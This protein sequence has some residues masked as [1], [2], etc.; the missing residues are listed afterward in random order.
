[1]KLIVGLGNPG[2]EYAKTRHNVGFMVIDKM[3]EKLQTPLTEKKFNGVFYK[4]KEV[5]LAKPLTYM[6]KSGDFVAAITNYYDV[7]L[8][9]VIIVYDDLDVVLGKAVIRQKGSAGGHNGMKDIIA[10]LHSEDIKR[11]KIGIGRDGNVI[12]YVLGKFSYA[13]S[14]VI[15]RIIEVASEALISFISNDIRFVMNK[16]SGKL[17]E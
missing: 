2:V 11:L 4:D 6:N 1:M 17:Y 12:D 13:D 3:A 14:I 15:D 7:A 9:D 5:I 10:K 8:E 16:Y